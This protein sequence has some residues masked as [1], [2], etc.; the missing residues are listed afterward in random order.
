MALMAM[1]CYPTVFLVCI[2]RT[3]QQTVL[4][5]ISLTTRT[6]GNVLISKKLDKI[7]TLRTYNLKTN[8]ANCTL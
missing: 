5:F 6:L 1:H 7:K 2:R 4:K 8:I 3:V